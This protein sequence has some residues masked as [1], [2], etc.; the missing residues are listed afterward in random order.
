MSQDSPTR[1]AAPAGG[2]VQPLVSVIIIF[3]TEE[4]SSAKPSK[5]L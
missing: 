4:N 2:A 5:L 1:G 3:Q